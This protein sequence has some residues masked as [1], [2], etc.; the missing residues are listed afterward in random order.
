MKLTNFFKCAFL[1]IATQSVS[2]VGINTVDPT[3]TLD[4]NGDLRI[5]TVENEINYEL[6]KDSLLVISRNGKLKSISSSAV[7]NSLEKSLVKSRFV[8]SNEIDVNL[9]SG[10]AQIL[11]FN[12]ELIDIYE[13]YNTSTYTFTPKKN[14]YYKIFATINLAPDDILGATSSLSVSLQVKKGFTIITES[15]SAL[16]GA[17]V[18]TSNVYIQPIR[19]IETVEYLTTNDEVSFY[20]LNSDLAPLDVDLLTGD[21][22]FFYIERIR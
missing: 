14:G 22:S 9:I 18:G 16:I 5:R 21:N 7:F 12:D 15:S 10:V 1:L 8:T 20:L 11:P 13:E 3:A 17:V 19:T 6:A 2:Q 4:I